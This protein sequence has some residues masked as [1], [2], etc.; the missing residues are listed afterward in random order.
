MVKCVQRTS[1][2]Y[3]PL[4][5]RKCPHAKYAWSCNKLDSFYVISRTRYVWGMIAITNHGLCTL[6]K[7]TG[8]GASCNS[9]CHKTDGGRGMT[10]SRRLYWHVASA[11]PKL[12]CI[13]GLKNTPSL[14]PTHS[15][16]NLLYLFKVLTIPQFLLSFSYG[17][18]TITFITMLLNLQVMS[19]VWIL[20]KY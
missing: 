8:V 6:F 2:D 15:H 14:F 13:C 11:A 10:L 3:T 12:N 4:L 9:M 17:D 18:R 7:M 5:C 19:I 16:I 1:P 20:I